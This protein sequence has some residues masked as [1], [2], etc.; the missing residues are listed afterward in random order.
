MTHGHLRFHFA[1]S[2]E[3]YTYNDEE[4]R[5]AERDNVKQT[6]GHDVEDKRETSDTAKDKR[7]HQNN[8]VENLGDVECGGSAGTNAGDRTALLHKVVGN[9]NRIEGDGN[10]EISECDDQN[11]EQHCVDN[12]VAG[13]CF[14]EE[15][16][17]LNTCELHDR[18]R[19][20]DDRAREDDRHNTGHVELDR[21][22]G[23]LTAVLFSANRTFCVL[24]RN[25]SFSVRHIS[26]E[27]EGA[28]D[29]ENDGNPKNDLE[30]N[31]NNLTTEDQC[32]GRTFC[33]KILV[34]L[35]EH[36]RQTGY[37]ICKK[38]H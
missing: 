11:E 38:D 1:Y 32:V 19:E 9:L 30:P 22:I 24:D 15:V 3:D 14:V 5:A 7:T 2:F 35:N 37:D 12:A 17:F 25:S 13:K 36:G 16:F 4:R 26:Y 20:R 21:E 28:D 29:N 23:A 33:L 8:L 6:A 10:V 18:D 34:E 31:G 27:D